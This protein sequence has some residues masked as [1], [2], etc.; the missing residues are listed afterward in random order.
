MLGFRNKYVIKGKLLDL[1]RVLGKY[2]PDARVYLEKIDKARLEKEKLGSNLLSYR[3]L[4]DLLN[5]MNELVI[6]KITN[7]IKLKK[8]YSV[9]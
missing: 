4:Y 3:N 7:N 5:V 8:M 2:S 9:I 1:F 6:S